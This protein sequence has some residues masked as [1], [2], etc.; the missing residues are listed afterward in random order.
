VTTKEQYEDAIVRAG[1]DRNRGHLDRLAKNQN[2]VIRKVA[3]EFLDKLNEEEMAQQPKGNTLQEAA[4]PIIN[5]EIVK[6]G[7]KLIIPEGVSLKQA[8]SLIDRRMTYEEEEVSLSEMF[9]VFPWDGAHAFDIVLT[10]TYGWSPAEAQQS[11]WGPVPPKM[12][13]I[14]VDVNQKKAVPWGTFSLP[15]V[16]GTI[17]TG[18]AL[19]DGR[20]C[21]A[22]SAEVKRLSQP[23]VEGLFAKV[24]A[25]LKTGSIYRGKAI[26]MRFLDEDGGMLKMP[27]PKFM[28]VS[29]IDE[30]QL[31]YSEAVQA[32]IE[33]NLFTPIR[34][35]H[36]LKANGIPVKRGVLLGGQ[37]GT[38]KTLG[39]RVA[40][41]YAVQVGV[42]FLYV[43]RA[44]ELSHAI[45]FARQYQ[46]PA[47][48]I[49]CED[50]DRAMNGERSV[51]MDD[52]LNIID[53]IDSKNSNII[54]VLTTNNLTGINAAM[55][56]PG[57][58]DSV[59]EVRAPDAEAVERLLRYYGGAAIS[60]DEDLTRVGQYLD[61]QIPAVIAEVVSRAKLS[62]LKLND[63]GVK[64]THLT[65]AALED[66]AASMT[67]QLDLLALQSMGKEGPPPLEVA[68]SELID[69]SVASRMDEI[70][71]VLDDVKA[72]VS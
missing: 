41:K 40:S 25:Y 7:D 30:S 19:R 60:S 51:E 69:K 36:E 10:E 42:T 57:R 68:L 9:D 31:V 23:V 65:A 71:G 28:D 6:T 32:D 8:K 48:V 49:F 3:L 56:R 4:E 70:R 11:F 64:V 24:R 5:A 21:F 33:T 72:Y 47:C 38:G 46:D 45:K 34:R 17:N 58:L 22:L 29:D 67:T 14:D 61:G 54:V 20:V 63:P 37:Y 53:G 55:L 52:I 39:A 43:T 26:R 50:I 62:Q 27:E 18:V 44:D 2:P 66:A 35:I 15:N 12:V 16:E 1:Y 59:I 13:T